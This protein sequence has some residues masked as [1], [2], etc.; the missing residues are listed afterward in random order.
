MSLVLIP[1]NALLN[2]VK[3]LRPLRPVTPLPTPGETEK[4]VNGDYNYCHKVAQGSMGRRYIC[5]KVRED[6]HYHSYNYPKWK[7]W[8]QRKIIYG[9]HIAKV[10]NGRCISCGCL[11]CPQCM[12]L[13]GEQ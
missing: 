10:I 13:L 6:I 8:K 11:R 3:P 2:Q 5:G 4:I 7:F 12:K 1:P 9:T